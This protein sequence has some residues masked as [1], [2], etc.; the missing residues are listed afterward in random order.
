MSVGRERLYD[1]WYNM[2]RRCYDPLCQYYPWYGGRGIEICFEWV[3]N[4]DAFYDWA[5]SNKYSDDLEID[6]IDNDGDYAPYNCR[7]VTRQE[8]CQNKS[9]N[10]KIEIDG[11]EYPTIML[12]AKSFNVSPTTI[13]TRYKKG[14]RGYDLVK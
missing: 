1:I 8:N 12:L 13:Y 2:Q 5:T 4:F 11:V 3:E 14:K 6:R 10:I 7:W 9:N